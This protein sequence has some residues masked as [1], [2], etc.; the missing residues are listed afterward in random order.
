M[1]NCQPTFEIFANIFDFLLLR[2]A[3]YLLSLNCATV[4]SAVCFRFL[5]VLFAEDGFLLFFRERDSQDFLSLSGSFAL[6][7]IYYIQGKRFIFILLTLF[8]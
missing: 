5:W 3:F 1:C 2:V 7:L 6:S 4:A 8:I